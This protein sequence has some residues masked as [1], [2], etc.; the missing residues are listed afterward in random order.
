VT[1]LRAG[2][3]GLGFRYWHIFSVFVTTFRLA[4]D[5]TQPPIQWVPGTL[6]PKVRRPEC[7]AGHS[8]PSS[9]EVRMCGAIPPFPHSVHGVVLVKRKDIFLPLPIVYVRNC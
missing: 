2:G 6:S 8:P 7:E 9:V 3:P 4:L 1:R 5:P